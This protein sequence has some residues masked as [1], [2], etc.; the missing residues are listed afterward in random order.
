MEQLLP[1]LTSSGDPSQQEESLLFRTS[2]YAPFQSAMTSVRP[3]AEQPLLP[4]LAR[5][6]GE[7]LLAAPMASHFRASTSSSLPEVPCH[8]GTRSKRFDSL[9][10]DLLLTRCGDSIDFDASRG[11]LSHQ[12]I[13]TSASFDD[14]GVDALP[15]HDLLRSCSVNSTISKRSAELDGFAPAALAR[16][17]SVNSAC[18]TF[19][20]QRMPVGSF[21]FAPPSNGVP[22]LPM[23]DLLRATTSGS[24][25]RSPLSDMNIG[26]ASQLP[27][28]RSVP[29]E[30][31][32]VCSVQEISSDS[33]GIRNG[34]YLFVVM[35]GDP[36]HMRLIH[37]HDLMTQNWEAGHTSLVSSREFTRNWARQWKLGDPDMFRFSVLYAGEVEYAE[38]V[39]VLSW[40]NCSGHY[41]PHRSDHTRV[42]LDSS[43][44]APVDLG[45]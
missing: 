37:E 35:V 44:F 38:G 22:E 25:P 27:K 26:Y 34:M 7:I 31:K 40:N 18:S 23:Y 21:L 28:Q 43:K 4:N 29:N 11:S 42:S 1:L 13:N 30:V 39:G 6:I 45:F 36:Q 5:T 15:F 12:L 9:T 32:K 19:S 24:D 16:G 8:S 10:Y 41:R 14:R 3:G 20:T 33:A 2:T 17:A